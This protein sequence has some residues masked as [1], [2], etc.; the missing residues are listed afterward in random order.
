MDIK[1]RRSDAQA[2][3]Y[4]EYKDIFGDAPETINYDTSYMATE[5]AFNFDV[6]CFLTV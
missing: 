1:P 4:D 6:S 3:F 5:S 2:K